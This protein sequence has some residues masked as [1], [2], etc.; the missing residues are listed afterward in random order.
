MS[1]DD[2]FWIIHVLNIW[3][4]SYNSTGVLGVWL[5]IYKYIRIYLKQTN[6]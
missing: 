1:N 6:S 2:V 5:L 3:G 4:V